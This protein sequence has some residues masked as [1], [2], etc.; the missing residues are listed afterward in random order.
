MAALGDTNILVYR[1]DPRFP[2]KQRIASELLRRGIEEDSVCVPHQAIV[3]FV[4]AVTR[5][6]IGEPIVQSSV[7]K[8][9]GIDLDKILKGKSIK[10]V[11]DHGPRR[12]RKGDFSQNRYA[13]IASLGNFLKNRLFTLPPGINSGPGSVES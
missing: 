12:R 5:P 4:A 1:F 7:D 2:A 10:T 6:L 11:H 9:F 3:E 8:F 13:Q